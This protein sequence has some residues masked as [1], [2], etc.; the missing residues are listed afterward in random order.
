MCNKELVIPS[1]AYILLY[2]FAI[3]CVL[4]NHKCNLVDEI[5]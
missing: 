5:Q 2:K 4:Q 1:Y 3:N